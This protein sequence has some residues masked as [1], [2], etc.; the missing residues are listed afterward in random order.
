MICVLVESSF[1][2]FAFFAVNSFEKKIFTAKL[3]KARVCAHT[4]VCPNRGWPSNRGWHAPWKSGA[5]S[6]A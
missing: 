6:A 3:A 5:F 4:V 2:T 1:A